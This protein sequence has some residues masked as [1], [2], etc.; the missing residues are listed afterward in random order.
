[1][2]CI[3]VWIVDVQSG[4]DVSTNQPLK[5][6][7]GGCLT[8]CIQGLG[9][10]VLIPMSKEKHNYTSLWHTLEPRDGKKSLSGQ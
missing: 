3:E 8:L 7:V 2:Q 6:V 9:F 4:R 1:M 10:R 5:L